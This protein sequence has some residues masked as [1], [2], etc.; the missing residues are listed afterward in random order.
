VIQNWG[1]EIHGESVE[2]NEDLEKLFFSVMLHHHDGDIASADAILD[3]F[4]N[5][6]VLLRP[7]GSGKQ[8][9]E[10]TPKLLADPKS[11][12]IK[13]PA[14]NY[15]KLGQSV[16]AVEDNI[17]HTGSTSRTVPKADETQR[18]G[19]PFK[20]SAALEVAQQDSG[21]KKKKRRKRSPKVKGRELC[22]QELNASQPMTSLEAEPLTSTFSDSSALSSIDS[23]WEGPD[24]TPSAS[25][26]PVL[27]QTL[28]D[29]P[30]PIP[31]Q[32]T[33]ACSSGSTSRSGS[34]LTSFQRC[35]SAEPPPTSRPHLTIIRPGRYHVPIVEP[36]LPM[37]SAKRPHPHDDLPLQ[38]QDQNLGS[39]GKPGKKR[40]VKTHVEEPQN[41]FTICNEE[42]P[43]SSAEYPPMPYLPFFNTSIK[44]HEAKPFKRLLKNNDDIDTRAP[45]PNGIK[46]PIFAAVSVPTNAH[47]PFWNSAS[48]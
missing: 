10:L 44:A 12:P 21:S 40:K 4:L 15:K 24:C 30:T 7:A 32:D 48:V 36:D 18:L 43:I 5:T 38:F 26:I 14:K 23:A 25:P 35:V 3:K 17:I 37:H 11:A 22:Q 45:L 1:R 31:I 42:I 28:V 29:R 39:E 13:L 47:C 33:P 34:S 16:L 8:K 6:K 27:A 19:R 46:P 9:A 20:R 2:L 41:S